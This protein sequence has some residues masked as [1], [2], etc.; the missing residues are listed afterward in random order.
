MRTEAKRVRKGFLARTCDSVSKVSELAIGIPPY[1]P[2]V[3]NS[4]RIK[5]YGES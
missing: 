5:M 3:T 4:L 2:R 1:T